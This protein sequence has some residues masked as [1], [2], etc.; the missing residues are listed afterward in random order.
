MGGEFC[1][2]A[3]LR[4]LAE[5]ACKRVCAQIVSLLRFHILASLDGSLTVEW[6]SECDKQLYDEF[7]S[8]ENRRLG[9]DETAP[10]P[11]MVFALISRDATA[12][13]SLPR[14]GRAIIRM[15]GRLLRSKLSRP[16]VEVALAGPEQS[17]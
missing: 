12:D 11:P 14:L 7:K 17:Q 16:P 9:R 10:H 15:V 3:H 4:N 13:A 6:S 1:G 2:E 5:R 8:Q